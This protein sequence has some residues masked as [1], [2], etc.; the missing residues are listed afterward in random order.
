MQKHIVYFKILI[1]NNSIYRAT[2]SIHLHCFLGVLEKY[3]N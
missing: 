2:K 1:F 3:T